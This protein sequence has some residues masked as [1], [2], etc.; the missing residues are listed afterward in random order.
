MGEIIFERFF[1]VFWKNHVP[2]VAQEWELEGIDGC[3][4]PHIIGGGNRQR[5][6]KGEITQ[7]IT[8]RVQ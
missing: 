8:F 3:G 5:P 4:F 2:S 1:V 6:V 7:R